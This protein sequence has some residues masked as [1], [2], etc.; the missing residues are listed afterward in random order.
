M[1]ELIPLALPV[2]S[3]YDCVNV[4][5]GQRGSY[6]SLYQEMIWS[7]VAEAADCDGYEQ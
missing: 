5:L 2:R 1:G 7:E 3:C 4:M 6:C